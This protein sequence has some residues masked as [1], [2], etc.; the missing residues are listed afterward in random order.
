MLNLV[1]A[2][3]LMAS[4]Q[5]I[6]LGEGVR[7]NRYIISNTVEKKAWQRTALMATEDDGLIDPSGKIASA[8]DSE[9]VAE[10]ARSA[11]Q[12]SETAIESARSSMESL[13]SVTN[14]IYD[15]VCHISFGIPRENCDNLTAWVLSETSDATNDY[16]VVRFSQILT[17]PPVRHVEYTHINRNGEE[18]SAAVPCVWE[19]PWDSSSITHR[20]TIRRPQKFASMRAVYRTVRADTIGGMDGFSFGS[21]V[22]RVDNVVAFTGSITNKTDGSV[23]TFKN[24]VLQND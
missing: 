17:V 3:C 10:T 12:I 9:A 18:V 6:M 7:T 20:C 4:G 19:F 14:R 11:G 1:F 21:S 2:V 24:G 15:S 23:I 16:Q 8:S 13:A 22:V 5:D